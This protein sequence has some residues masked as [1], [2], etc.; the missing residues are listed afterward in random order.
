MK[1]EL[2]TN[3]SDLE[4]LPPEISTREL[5]AFLGNTRHCVLFYDIETRPAEDEVVLAAFQDANVKLPPYPGVFDPMKVAY[6]NTKDVEKRK[7]KL[8]DDMVKHNIK[9]A[10]WDDECKKAKEEAWQEF[11]KNATL[12]SD[13]GRVMAIGYGLK[14]G[15]DV[16]LCLDVEP[17]CERNLLLRFWRFVNLIRKRDGKLISFNGNSFDIPFCTWRSWAYEDINPPRLVTKYRKYEDFCVDCH[18]EYK[19]G[20]YGAHIKLK[21]LARLMRVPGKLEGMTGDQ[22][23]QVY[24]EDQE[25]ALDYLAHDVHCLAA[26]AERMRLT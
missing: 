3:L 5:E 15:T 26:V 18:E 7:A 21:K 24:G 6:G 23:W 9:L 12:D 20:V 10:S 13:A 25:K 17:E 4:A 1:T 16:Q 22:F 11:R 8:T 2:P 14:R 19:L